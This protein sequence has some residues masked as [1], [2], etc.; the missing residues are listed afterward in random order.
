MDSAGRIFVPA[1]W[2][3]H[4]R[5]GAAG[6][7]VFDRTGRY[8]RTIPLPQRSVRHIALGAN[9]EVFTLGL[10]T[11]FIRG[12]TD[13][14]FLLGRYTQEGKLAAAF[15]PCPGHGAE[16][17]RLN[18]EI[19]R[20][21]IWIKDG[22]LYQL[23]P[24]SRVVRVFDAKT[25]RWSAETTLEAPGLGVSELWRVL[26]LANGEYLAEWRDARVLTVHNA[27]GRVIARAENAELPSSVPITSDDHGAVTFLA[28]D[29]QRGLYFI[30]TRVS[31]HR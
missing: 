7:F 24:L 2:R 12:R 16:I 14:C 15:S 29:S 4:P 30:R 3:L 8:Q 27:S 18:T 19:D 20:G 10:D 25:G 5:G 13:S 21:S 6:I 17:A 28:S 23:M 9:G 31:I 11:N 22:N 1:T 26:S